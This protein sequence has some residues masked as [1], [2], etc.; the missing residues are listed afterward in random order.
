LVLAKSYPTAN[1]PNQR[2][3]WNR[4]RSFQ[5]LRGADS[6][7]PSKPLED[8]PPLPVSN[9]TKNKLS[10]FQFSGQPNPDS[11]AKQTVISLLSDDDK[12]NAKAVKPNGLEAIQEVGN[13]SSQPKL[14]EPVKKEVPLTPAGRLALPDLIGMGDV[15][16]AVQDI[17]PE[18][19]IEWDALRSSSSMTGN[20]RARK[21]TRSSSP[22]ASP[23][24]QLAAFISSRAQVDPGSD[25]WG[26]YSLS[27][28]N[29]PTPQGQSVPALAHIMHTSSP[30]PEK[31]GT[32]PRSGGG[33]KRANSCGNHFPKR[34]RV[35]NIENDDVFTESVKLGPSKLSVLLERVQEGLTQPKQSPPIS[36]PAATFLYLPTN[37]RYEFDDISCKQGERKGAMAAPKLP[38]APPGTKMVPA[39][40]QTSVRSNSSDYG[41]FDDD[42][43]DTNLLDVF[44]PK[45]DAT[46]S[47]T[48]KASTSVRRPLDSPP[49]PRIPSINNLEPRQAAKDSK[50]SDTST[51]KD[52]FDDSDEDMFT[53]DLEDIVAKFDTQNSVPAK[54][55]PGPRKMDGISKVDSDDEFGDGGLDEEDFEAA[56][57]A[58]TQSKQQAANS[59]LLV[60]TQ[61]S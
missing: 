31:E 52:E 49:Q 25:L 61:F 37:K 51:L 36:G 50:S 19:R 59:L 17:S 44:A 42:D 46:I 56:E 60:R 23:P 38:P 16:R 47:N 35:V 18:D 48:T 33:L 40:H 55:S 30:Q 54:A 8:K 4:N 2:P 12:E 21:R 11:L 34:R 5:G 20:T 15:K 27:G 14:P 32:S 43:L 58:A 57:V 10:V 1:Y 9:A 6:K 41:E 26:R 39:K 28:S 7:L 13:N 3:Q 53:A 24:G 29:A 22:L 45:P